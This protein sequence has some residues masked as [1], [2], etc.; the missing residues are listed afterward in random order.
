VSRLNIKQSDPGKQRI[1]RMGWQSE[2]PDTEPDSTASTIVEDNIS[3][4]SE[5]QVDSEASHSSSMS[6][7]PSLVSSFA[8]TV[9]TFCFGEGNYRETTP[10]SPFL[11]QA[12]SLR[13]LNIPITSEP[14]WC[15]EWAGPLCDP[16]I[17]PDTEPYLLQM[18]ISTDF[19]QYYL[20][21]PMSNIVGDVKYDLIT[22]LERNSDLSQ[23]AQS[24]S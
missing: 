2:S 10:E 22:L 8:S 1:E 17:S 6:I 3:Y 24:S 16:S 4:Q 23:I 18:P 7:V 14:L 12:F 11:S 20:Q 13:G 9:S 15:E 19:R 21:T 5:E